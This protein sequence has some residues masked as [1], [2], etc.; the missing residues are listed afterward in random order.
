MYQVKSF[1]DYVQLYLKGQPSK[2]EDAPRNVVHELVNPRWEVCVTASDSGFQQSS[3]VNSIATTKVQ[4][5]LSGSV[6]RAHPSPHLQGGT[7]VQAVVDQLIPKILEAV[8]KKNKGGM[9]LRPFHIKGHLWVFVNCLIENPT[10][11]SQ[12]KENMTLKAKSFG[13]SC[14]LSD[15]FI[16]QVVIR[17]VMHV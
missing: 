6:T 17:V 7:H 13:S 11:D 15:K 3:F 14:S 5:W 1:K 9:E 10:F 12:T 8:K 16:K 4:Q 2:E